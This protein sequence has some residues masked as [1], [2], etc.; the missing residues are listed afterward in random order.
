MGKAGGSESERVDDPSSG[1]VMSAVKAFE[2]SEGLR[3]R[4]AFSAQIAH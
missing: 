2:E 3:L 4:E 1:I